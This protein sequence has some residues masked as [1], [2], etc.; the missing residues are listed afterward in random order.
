[1]VL[2]DTRGFE[3]AGVDV[4]EEDIEHPAVERIAART[5][6]CFGSLPL[7]DSFMNR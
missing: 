3:G 2:S 4:S 6:F 1:V 5:G 7:R